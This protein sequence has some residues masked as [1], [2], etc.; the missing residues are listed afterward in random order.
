MSVEYL[1]INGTSDHQANNYIPNLKS[2][3]MNF[4]PKSVLA[5]D[6]SK[7]QFDIKLILTEQR[8]Q[9]VDLAR[10]I[11]LVRQAIGDQEA[12]Q[13]SDEH[14]SSTENSD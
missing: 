2:L 7:I 9:R 6:L 14:E 12:L 8:A 1:S 5:T 4:L 11:Q 3:T 10:V 13:D